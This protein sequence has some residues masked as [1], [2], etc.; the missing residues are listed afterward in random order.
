MLYHLK[1]I[2]PEEINHDLKLLKRI[3]ILLLRCEF[4]SADEHD[5]YEITRRWAHDSSHHGQWR[6]IFD[7]RQMIS[8]CCRMSFSVWTVKGHENI[9]E[10]YSVRLRKPR[11]H[12][13]LWDWNL[14]K[15]DICYGLEW[16][17]IL[18]KILKFLKS[19]SICLPTDSSKKFSRNQPLPL[20]FLLHAT[21][22]HSNLKIILEKP[23]W[24]VFFN[25]QNRS[26]LT[27]WVGKKIIHN[28]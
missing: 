4:I 22:S 3:T 20:V 27:L 13:G 23:L 19:W 24:V 9:C 15:L 12:G 6:E 7:F 10:F 8:C 28:S 14:N 2:H 18:H 11:H 16:V 26:S 21:L 5:K 1:Y 25:R 17:W